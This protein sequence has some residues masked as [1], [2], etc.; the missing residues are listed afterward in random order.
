[1]KNHLISELSH[2]LETKFRFVRFRLTFFLE[3]V[4]YHH[5]YK[6]IYDKSQPKP[7]KYKQLMRPRIHMQNSAM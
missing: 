5:I 2:F 7:M 3:C 4:D 1:M 6:S